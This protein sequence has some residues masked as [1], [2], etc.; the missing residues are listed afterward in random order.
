MHCAHVIR[1]LARQEPR[2]LANASDGIRHHTLR[3]TYLCRRHYVHG[4]TRAGVTLSV[5][6]GTT[7]RGAANDVG[8]YDP[9]EP[10]PWD[11]Y[12][13]CMIDNGTCTLHA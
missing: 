7:L 8:A 11:M 10:N 2:S 13:A 12:V 6:A 5:S 4:T 3:A 1:T 9:P